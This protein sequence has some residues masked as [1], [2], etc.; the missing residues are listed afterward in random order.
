[1][2]ANPKTPLLEGTNS[3]LQSYHDKFKKVS[4]DFEKINAYYYML[5]SQNEFIKSQRRN[6]ASVDKKDSNGNKIFSVLEKQK[7]A[8][9]FKTHYNEAIMFHKKLES[10]AKSNSHAESKLLLKQMINDLNKLFQKQ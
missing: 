2:L 1:M 5:H 4:G 3:D 9:E 10:A 6:K 8:S 7:K